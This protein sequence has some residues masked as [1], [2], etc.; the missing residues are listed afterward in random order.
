MTL[1]RALISTY[2]DP[3]LPGGG[4]QYSVDLVRAW[5]QQGFEVHVLC[6]DHPRKLGGFAPLLQEKK[7]VLHP[8][9]SANRLLLSH[10]QDTTLYQQVTD[11]LSKMK[12]ESV[13]IHNFHGMLSAVEAAVDHEAP[14]FYTALD[15][16]LLCASW[17]LYD[18]SLMPCAGPEAD[19]CR[20]CLRSQQSIPWM[21]HLLAKT[22]PWILKA[23]GKNADYIRQFSMLP[24]YYDQ[25]GDHLGHMLPLLKRFDGVL[26]ISPIMKDILTRFGVDARRV[27]SN[28][29]GADFPKPIQTEPTGAVRLVF[30]GHMAPIKGFHIVAQAVEKLPRGLA[31][32]IRTYGA[33][34]LR[35]HNGLSSHAKTYISAFKT[36]IGADVERELGICDALVIPSL[37]RENTPYAVLRALA[38]NRPVLSSDQPGISHLI[39][40]GVNGYLLPPGNVEAWHE[41]LTLVAHEP[42]RLR[43]LRP[44]CMYEKS[45]QEYAEEIESIIIASKRI[46]H[47]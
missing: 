4:S 38:A 3:E 5:I 7:L 31:L 32:E 37:W 28:V 15:F 39:R 20:K 21:K 29:Q 18:G 43:R 33:D 36:L 14:T 23:L 17:Y 16:G 24:A 12:P 47:V 35:Y 44:N 45:V 26:T 10:R 11:L 30:L 22:P 27:H 2:F 46:V 25:I 41:M 13:H 42:D 40:E 34:A 9:V 8:L 1:R 6:S 19:K